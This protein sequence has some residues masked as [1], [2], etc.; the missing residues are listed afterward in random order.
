MKQLFAGGHLL[1][2]ELLTTSCEY[3]PLPLFRLVFAQIA[4]SCKAL[5]EAFACAGKPQVAKALAPFSIPVMLLGGPQSKIK[6]WID[7]ALSGLDFVCCEWKSWLY[8]M[9]C[10]KIL[11]GQ[12]YQMCEWRNDC[13]L[14]ICLSLELRKQPY[15][16]SYASADDRR[17]RQSCH[18]CLGRK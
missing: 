11:R 15:A 7:R 4:A 9:S 12:D 1:N 2:R 6:V 13:L 5:S 18:Q 8:F 10:N 14:I 3:D 16:R 17:L